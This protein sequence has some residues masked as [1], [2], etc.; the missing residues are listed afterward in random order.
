MFNAALFEL[1]PLIARIFAA[2]PAMLI[3]LVRINAPDVRVIAPVT[4]DANVIKLMFD[5]PTSAIACRSDPLPESF[6]FSTVRCGGNG[7][8][9]I[10]TKLFVV[11]SGGE[12]LS[13]ARTVTVFVLGRCAGVGVQET[14][15]VGDIVRPVGK[16][17]SCSVTVFVGTSASLT[18]TFVFKEAPSATNCVAGTVN[19]GAVFAS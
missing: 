1:F 17:R 19:T 8:S 6:V 12:P 18:E 15:P 5:T 13:K 4:F 7:A 14:T 11:L 2:G 10:T 9:A 3:S 16:D